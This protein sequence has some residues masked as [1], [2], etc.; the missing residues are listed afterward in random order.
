MP[1]ECIGSLSG[2]LLYIGSFKAP[3]RLLLWVGPRAIDHVDT[4]LNA[5]D[6]A[7]FVL[8][9]DHVLLAAVWAGA[10]SSLRHILYHITTSSA[11]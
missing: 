5:L 4:A 11:S 6:G 2:W 8:V 9:S 10:I 7:L 3:Q 1:Y